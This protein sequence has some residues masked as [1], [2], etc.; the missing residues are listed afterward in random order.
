MKAKDRILTLLIHADHYI[1]GPE[2][3]RICGLGS[4]RLYPA[5]VALEKD[6]TAESDWETPHSGFPRLRMYR[7][8]RQGR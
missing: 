7:W 2:I 8:K 6:G 3:G 5:L 4:W 1:A